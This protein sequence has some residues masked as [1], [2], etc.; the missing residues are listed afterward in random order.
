MNSRLGE[1]TILRAEPACPFELSQ[2][3]LLAPA[4]PIGLC[5]GSCQSYQRRLAE[6]VRAEMSLWPPLLPFWFIDTFRVTFIFF[7]FFFYSFISIFYIF[8]FL[9]TRTQKQ[10]QVY[11]DRRYRE[12]GLW[13]RAG[14]GFDCFSVR[15]RCLSNF[16][17][18]I[19]LGFY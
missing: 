3:R 4:R 13:A 15:K 12:F 14:V 11:T 16:F 5:P 7:L 10:T 2:S 17:F 8:L 1:V 18:W 9:Y 19:N 6:R